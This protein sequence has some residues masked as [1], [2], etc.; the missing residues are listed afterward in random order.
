MLYSF[1]MYL[2]TVVVFNDAQG[3]HNFS[4]QLL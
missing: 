3:Q 1:R 2:V 4:Y